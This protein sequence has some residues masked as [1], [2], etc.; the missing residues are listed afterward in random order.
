[1]K[2]QAG[3]IRRTFQSPNRLHRPAPAKG[4]HRCSA[5]LR[6]HRQN[7]EIFLG[8]KDKR[9]GLAQILAHHVLRLIAQKC[10]IRPGIRPGLFILRP[11]ADHHQ[12]PL[13]QPGK[14][15][16]IASDSQHQTDIA[17]EKN[18]IDRTVK[19]WPT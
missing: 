9:L 15:L 8:G 19:H 14:R 11:V 17:G 5:R 12:L 6:L 10:D 1:M 13:R 3:R 16:A 4:D 18:Q 7:A 2:K